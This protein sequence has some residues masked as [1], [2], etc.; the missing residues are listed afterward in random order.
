MT[1][2]RPQES[3]PD[4]PEHLL[5]RAIFGPLGGI[6]EISA[7]AATGTWSLTDASPAGFATAHRTQ[8]TRLRELVQRIG[9]FSDATLAILDDLGYLNEHSVQAPS[10]LMWSSAYEDV[11]SPLE[12]AEVVRRMSRTGADLQ[13]TRFLQALTE[14]AIARGRNVAHGAELIAEAVRIAVGLLA[15]ALDDSDPLTA[16]RTSFRTWRTA[17]LTDLLLPNSPARPEARPRFREYAHALD[18]LLSSGVTATGRPLP[19]PAPA[20]APF[21]L[22]SDDEGN[23]VSVTVTGRHPSPSVTGTIMFAAEIGIETPFVRGRLD[24]ALWSSRLE[25]WGRV[26]DRLEAGEDAGWMVAERGP[27]LS[28][29]LVGE[30]D[31]PEV[32][33]EDVTTSMVTVRVPVALRD[34]WIARHRERLA[35]V[36]DARADSVPYLPTNPQPRRNTP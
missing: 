9:E 25:Q 1:T 19:A 28:V 33:V 16:Q 18:A 31:C 13:L 6:V 32:I 24:L 21:I 35:T 20:P 27:S 4:I 3:T 29:R 17:H 11:S 22:L 2:P 23:S 10:L 30:R 34:D 5:A 26:L 14:A 36:L 7:V 15:G 8:V 12:A